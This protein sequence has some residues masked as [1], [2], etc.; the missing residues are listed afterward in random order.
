MRVPHEKREVI[1]VVGRSTSAVERT[2]G[3]RVFLAR[4]PVRLIKR[5]LNYISERGYLTGK[6]IF[7]G[8]EF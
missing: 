4:A 7:P 2:A 3:L 5:E 8:Q 1:K 6:S